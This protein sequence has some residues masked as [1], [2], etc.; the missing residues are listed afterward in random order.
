MLA[1]T[2]LEKLRKLSRTSLTVIRHTM[3]SKRNEERHSRFHNISIVGVRLSLVW[4]N[5]SSVTEV[6]SGATGQ[7]YTHFQ[8]HARSANPPLVWKGLLLDI[9]FLGRL[10]DLLSHGWLAA[11]LSKLFHIY[12]P[13]F[14]EC[15][16]QIQGQQRNRR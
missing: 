2:L 16:S 6:A 4:D 11:I 13:A 10:L 3:L 5:L 1:Q 14:Y 12:T 8:S 9:I 15:C 7:N